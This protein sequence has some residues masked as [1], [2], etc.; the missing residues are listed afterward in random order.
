MPLDVSRIRAIC[1][2]V[3]GTLSNTDDQFVQR[4]AGWLG[5][6][7]F[8][9]PDRDVLPFARWA[10]MRTETPGQ[11]VFGLP[12]RLHLDGL[13]GRMGDW[14]YQR[15]LGSEHKP[16][17]LIDGVADVLHSL[18]G[19]FPMA[20]VSA[21]GAR[22]TRFF[23]QQFNLEGYFNPVVTGLTCRHT[24]PF[25]DPI[26]YAAQQMGV[27]PEECLMVGD[28]T[29]DMRAAKAAGAQTVGVLCGF[30]ESGELQQ[31]GADVILPST[32]DLL[33]VMQG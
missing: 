2:D 30:G 17:L 33:S 22:S 13:L 18:E 20:V 4:L 32:A 12:D 3:D 11:L 28:T 16:F 25:P 14:V 1:F 15:G 29:V 8:A 6:L 24:K 19:R 10:V 27:A 23:L 5:P 21:R 26:L 7:R 9:F 31:A